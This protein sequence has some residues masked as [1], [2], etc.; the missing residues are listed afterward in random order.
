M[1]MWTWPQ[2]YSMFEVTPLNTDTDTTQKI[3]KH[4]GAVTV[5][6]NSIIIATAQCYIKYGMIFCM[7]QV[8]GKYSRCFSFGYQLQT[9][10]LQCSSEL[11]II[12]YYIPLLSAKGQKAY[13][14]HN[15]SL[16]SVP[17]NRI[18]RIW[19]T[20]GKHVLVKK[21]HDFFLSTNIVPIN[22]LT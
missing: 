6:C 2:V 11:L 7:S 15:N 12:F 16:A 10:M 1:E 20:Y 22:P 3:L 8:L 21:I 18:I 14:Q 4:S 19:N 13:T 9:S 5:F 17:F